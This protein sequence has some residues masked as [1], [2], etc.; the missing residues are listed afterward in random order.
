MGD[1]MRGKLTN[2]AAVRSAAIAC[3]ALALPIGAVAQDDGGEALAVVDAAFDAIRA[4]DQ[5][6]MLSLFLPDGTSTRLRDARE[7]APDAT[8]LRRTTNAA[9]ISQAFNT[10]SY[11][12]EQWTE[13][14]TVLVD[15]D[16]A[17]VWGRYEFLIN[18]SIAHCGVNHV[19]LVRLDGRWRITNWTWSVHTE[20]CTRTPAA[21]AFE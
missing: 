18:G 4:R 16:L 9:L 20:N 5:A 1:V 2:L 6:E 11:I 7:L 14:P 13:T 10:D 17:L 21:P 8:P 19:D 15:G 12:E 3:V